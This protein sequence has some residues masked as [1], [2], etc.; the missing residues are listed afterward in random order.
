MAGWS[1]T[2]QSLA[3]ET[4]AMGSGHLR[5]DAAFIEENKRIQVQARQALF[6]F[7]TLASIPFNES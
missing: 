4:A 2:D 1:R 6:P 3:L 5:I 7:L